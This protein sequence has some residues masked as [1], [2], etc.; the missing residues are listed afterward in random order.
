VAALLDQGWSAA[1]NDPAKAADV[2]RTVI[3]RQPG[4]AE[5]YYGLGYALLAQGKTAEGTRYLCMVRGKNPKPDVL[6]DVD[7][8]LGNRQLT[9]P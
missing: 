2:F 5:G 9:C 8:I 3:A 7:G 1:D 4:N 6:A